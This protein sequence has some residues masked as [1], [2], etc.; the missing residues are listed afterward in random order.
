MDDPLNNKEIQRLTRR[1]SASPDL[2]GEL[3]DENVHRVLLAMGITKQEMAD[4]HKKIAN[5]IALHGPAEGRS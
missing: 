1:V 5:T 2:L 3:S 4:F